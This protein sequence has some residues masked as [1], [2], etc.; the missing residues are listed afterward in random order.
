MSQCA[1]SSFFVVHPLSTILLL[2]PLYALF[3]LDTRS[4][5]NIQRTP[6]GQVHLAMT[7]PFYKLKILDRSA[8]AGIRDRNIA[9]LG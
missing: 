2:V 7:K 3:E 4:S 1:S 6:N 9:P 5:E 8:T